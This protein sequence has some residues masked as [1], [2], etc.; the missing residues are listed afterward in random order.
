MGKKQS[1][2]AIGLV[3]LVCGVGVLGWWVILAAIAN[4]IFIHEFLTMKGY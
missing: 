3:T 1:A 2:L 4:T